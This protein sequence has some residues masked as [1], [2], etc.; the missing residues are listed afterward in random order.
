MQIKSKPGML[1]KGSDEETIS[2]IS[3]NWFRVTSE[4]LANG[5]FKF[6]KRRVKKIPKNSGQG[7]RVLGILNPRIKIIEKALLNALEPI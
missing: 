2:G 7:Y 1:T 4:K 6:P 3:K 5:T